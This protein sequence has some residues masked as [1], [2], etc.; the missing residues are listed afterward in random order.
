MSAKMIAEEGSLAGLVVS[1]D[2]GKQWVLGRGQDATV[3]IADPLAGDRH[4]RLSLMEEG[5]QVEPLDKNSVQINDEEILQPRLLKHGDVLKIGD[6]RFRFYREIG[7]SATSDLATETPPPPAETIVTHPPEPLIEKSEEASQELTPN[8]G[9][10][11]KMNSTDTINTNVDTLITPFKEDKIAALHDELTEELSS[12]DLLSHIDFGLDDTGPFLLKVIRGPNNGA[13]FPMEPGHSYVLGT[14]P[15]VC[16]VVFHD[17]SISRQH[18][19]ITINPDLTIEIEDLG[20][21]NGTSVDETKITAKTPLGEHI[22]VM[23]G[24]TSFIVFNRDSERSTI[25]TPFLPS[26]VRSLQDKTDEQKSE[27]EARVAAEQAAK[28]AALQAKI[29]EKP[30][31]EASEPKMST[32]KKYLLAGLTSGL[33]LFF[34]LGTS[35]LFQTK[36]FVEPVHNTSQ[37]IENALKLYPNLQYSY[38]KDS[39][40]LFLIGHVLNAAERSQL[41][42][43]LES[44]PFVRTVDDANLIIDE[45]VLKETN[46]I[47]NK[48]PA[49]TGISMRSTA[50]GRFVISGYL[51]KRSDADQL[52]DLLTQNFSYLDRL[53]NRVVVEESEVDSM[54]QLVSYAG[55]Y[56]VT[57]QMVNGEVILEG[58]IAPE[59]GDLLKD[60]IEKIKKQQSVRLVK[61]LV[62]INVAVPQQAFIDVT[63]NYPVTGSASVSGKNVSVFIRGRI[64]SRGDRLDDM[65]I[66]EIQRNAILLEKDGVQ[67]RIEYNK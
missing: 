52:K 41:M 30:A 23:L 67:Y 20:S 38:N 12:G 53:D 33:L 25:I 14:D 65:V 59:N 6:N 7:D 44:L 35:T 40:R 58:S 45:Y 28:I 1:L 61:N 13:E 8:L 49:W 17:M 60:V 21:R 15:Q 5:M 22:I 32:F 29:A 10:T 9:I 39:K 19:R 54:R 48:N 51:K 56:N 3:L 50:P 66:T 26:I 55:L 47:L 4:V 42:Y 36:T 16:D 27:E 34:A 63:A 37:D 18:A 43:A 62:N 11:E 64:L 2:Q 57:L 24:T 31:E 46:Q